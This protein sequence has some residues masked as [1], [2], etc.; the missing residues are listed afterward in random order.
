M[1]LTE[2]L[3]TLRR[4][5]PAPLDRWRWPTHSEPTTT[6]VVV[7]GISLMRLFEISGSPAVLTGD[8]PIPSTGTDVTVLL[9]RITLRVDTQEDKRI[10][11]T[12]CCFDGVDAAWE[13]CRL[14]GRASSARATSIELIPGEQGEVAWPHPVAML[15]ADLREG[16]LVVVP[17]LGAVTLGDVRPRTAGA[18]PLPEEV[19][20]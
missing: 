2:I 13:E 3:P 7:G 19:S 14:I 1:T 18:V 20:R 17:C 15:P 10:A 9:L 5:I 4:S 11:L 6:D 8:L 16:D 12:D